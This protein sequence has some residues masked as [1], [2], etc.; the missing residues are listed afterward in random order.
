MSRN[1]VYPALTAALPAF[2]HFYAPKTEAAQG[3]LLPVGYGYCVASVVSALWLVFIMGAKVGSARKAA[4]IP[5]PQM[6][7]EKQEAEKSRE[8]HLF[9]CAQRVHQNTLE[10]LP[11]YMFL[12]LFTGLFYPRL[13]TGLASTWVVSRVLYM[14]GYNS[15]VPRNRVTGAIIGGLSFIGLLMLATYSAFTIVDSANYQI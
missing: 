2:Y 15:G 11:S 12:V 9:N 1:V 3:L 13:S 5:Y 7:A 6:Y 10:N 8:A 14:V 4:G